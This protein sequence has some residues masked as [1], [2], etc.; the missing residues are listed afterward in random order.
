MTLKARDLM[1]TDLRTVPENLPV[2]L[3]AEH[4]REWEISGVPVTSSNGTPAGVVSLTDIAS[5]GTDHG[6]TIP[7]RTNPEYFLRG[8]AERLNPEDVDR[9]RIEDEGLEVRD[10]MTR[11]IYD[12]SPD[13]PIAEVLDLM[14]N[15]HIHRVLVTDPDDGLV[16]I[17]S[18]FDVLQHMS[19]S[20]DFAPPEVHVGHS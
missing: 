16:G 4:L 17:I 13:A 20:D 7:D 15:A 5:I 18:T 10:I 6:A 3:L 9:L 11:T 1:K 12:V 19:E 8:W 14:L 2:R